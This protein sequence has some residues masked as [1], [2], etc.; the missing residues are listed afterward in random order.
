MSRVG[1]KILGR[2]FVKTE[3]RE[4]DTA[5]DQAYSGHDCRHV[6]RQRASEGG[7]GGYSEG[8]EEFVQKAQLDPK[9]GRVKR[10]KPL[11]LTNSGGGA[12]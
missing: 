8:F 3:R 6:K 10:R 9:Q 12:L 5:K 1:S 11:F 2:H 7:A 4:Q